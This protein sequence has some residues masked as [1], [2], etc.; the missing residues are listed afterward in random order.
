[1]FVSL[2]VPW[3]D[4]PFLVN[5]FRI[6]SARQLATLRELGLRKIAYD[7]TRSAAEP[8]PPGGETPSVP[9]SLPEP[10]ERE[11]I[12]AKRTRAA[13]MAEQRDLIRSC[14]KAY[15]NCVDS[16]RDLL[17]DVLHYPA[18]ATAQAGAMV[19]ELAST[20]SRMPAPP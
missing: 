10:G 13:R 12:E 6:S 7:P 18:D 4:H 2:D 11:H 9:P 8:L 16:T 14:E 20:S 15:A 3:L 5:S 19:G 1:M 17:A